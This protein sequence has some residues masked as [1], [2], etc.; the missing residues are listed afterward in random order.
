MSTSNKAVVAFV[1][2]FLTALLAQVADKTEFTDLT[3]LQ[4][5]IA[6]LSAVVTA[7]AVWVVPNRPTA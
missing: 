7:G 1:L 3:V 5:I 4:W 2:A 6:V